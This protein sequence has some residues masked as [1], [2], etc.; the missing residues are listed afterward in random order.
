M[1][2][3]QL[4]RKL[5]SIQEEHGDLELYIPDDAFIYKYDSEFGSEVKKMYYRKWEDA[6]YMR[7]YISYGD[8][9]AKDEELYD[10]DLSKPIFKAVIL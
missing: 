4:I 9:D 2:I 10:V 8:L 3:S 6:D 5:Q 7:E 1:K